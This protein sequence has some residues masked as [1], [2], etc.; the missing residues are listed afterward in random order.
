MRRRNARWRRSVGAGAAGGTALLGLC[1]A[2]LYGWTVTVP[3][4]AVVAVAA[5]VIA[6]WPDVRDRIWAAAAGAGGV[7]LAATAAAWASSG[8]RY[9]EGATLTGG[10]AAAEA[11]GLVVLTVLAVRVA[12]PPRAV[13]GAGLAGVAV[14]CWVL[15]FGDPGAVT[16]IALG[17]WSL[18]ALLAVAA[19]L[20]LRSLD[21]RRRRSVAAARRRQ[22]RELASDLHDFVAHDVSAMLAQAQAGR[23]VAGH[24]PDAAARAFETIERAALRALASLDRT[25][26]MLHSDPDTDMDGGTGRGT[27]GDTGGGV[28]PVPTLDD[29]P[30]LAS[31]FTASGGVP[32]RLDLDP[33]LVVPREVSAT[34][35]RVVT[36]ALTN[37]R[38]HAP[39]ASGVEVS[40]RR[41][42]GSRTVRVVVTDDAPG[43]PAAPPGRRGG[44][45][46]PGLRERVEV[47]GGTLAAGPRDPSGWRV[48]AELPLGG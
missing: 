13:A 28:A 4:A 16:A 46:L 7:S 19:G 42:A 34:A 23:I 48:A 1:A 32:V 27:G 21:D 33:G 36:E 29:L 10:L 17:A 41:A 38:R 24:D 37:V 31:A 11:G 5:G 9:V 25:V 12:P 14:P 20:Y 35:Y 22:R 18:P 6:G 44:L 2:P 45:G 39:G 47:L 15:R 30:G 3:V 43:V 26:R 8:D 40:V